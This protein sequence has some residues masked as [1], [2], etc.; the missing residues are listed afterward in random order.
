MGILTNALNEI[1]EGAI[2]LGVSQLNS[3]IARKIQEGQ[4][5]EAAQAGNLAEADL[6][7]L[8]NY[9][10]N[11]SAPLMRGRGILPGVHSLTAGTQTSYMPVN[12]SSSGAID[13][14]NYGRQLPQVNPKV[15]EN[16]Y[17]AQ[18]YLARANQF[19]ENDPITLQRKAQENFEKER[20]GLLKGFLG[21]AFK[22]GDIGF[23]EGLSGY[24]APAT[25]NLSR[26]DR[27]TRKG[28]LEAG[29][30]TARELAQEPFRDAALQR[31]IRLKQTPG[32]RAIGSDGGENGIF[33]AITPQDLKHMEGGIKTK[34]DYVL[35]VPDPNDP[36]KKIKYLNQRGE[37]A[38]EIAAD[39]LSRMKK[40]NPLLAL[41]EA[42][43][44]EQIIYEN[45]L[46]PEKKFWQN[47]TRKLQ[48]QGIYRLGV[49]R[50]VQELLPGMP[51]PTSPPNLIVPKSTLQ[52]SE[53]NQAQ[54]APPITGQQQTSAPGIRQDSSTI[55]K[56]NQAIMVGATPD[57][58][59]RALVD[60]G[61]NPSDYGY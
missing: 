21:D 10:Q 41:R 50:K 13:A 3:N 34:S 2:G 22:Q 44:E 39:K 15:F 23:Q 32:A 38:L 57:E 7:N 49:D 47:E 54:T 56:I 36:T 59:R 48:Q 25:F 42:T 27:I 1:I 14:I 28:E 17:T 16:P 4:L 18:R 61:K 51:E 40:K 5:N 55:E 29:K 30:T 12:P 6:V 35:T 37:L 45:S 53:P 31:Q 11:V 20:L 52:F 33:S 43:I 24:D 60:E 26:Q 8:Q 46:S 9:Q 58:I 19:I